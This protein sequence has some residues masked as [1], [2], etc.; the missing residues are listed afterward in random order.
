MEK[1]LKNGLA[2]SASTS[3]SRGGNRIFNILNAWNRVLWRILN[4]CWQIRNVIAMTV[5]ALIAFLPILAA[6]AMLTDKAY[7]IGGDIP[8]FSA[9]LLLLAETVKTYLAGYSA[10]EA[11]GICLLA[12]ALLMLYAQIIDWFAYTANIHLH[13]KGKWAAMKPLLISEADY[14]FAAAYN[15]VWK[16]MKLALGVGI[17]YFVWTALNALTVA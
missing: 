9:V 8:D 3:S 7:E 15:F 13:C 4:E 17:V 11:A 1:K 16:A 2:Y 10:V 5:I 14:R 6:L 12:L